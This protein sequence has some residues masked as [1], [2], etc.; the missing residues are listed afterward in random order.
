MNKASQ[1]VMLKWLQEDVA[2]TVE[3]PNDR[4]VGYIEGK[5]AALL[6]SGT[7]NWDEYEYF[8]SPLVDAGLSEFGT[9]SPPM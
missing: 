1:K 4:R 8:L 3:H 7:I 5:L 2:E 9:Y 6:Q